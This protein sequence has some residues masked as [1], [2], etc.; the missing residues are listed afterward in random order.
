MVDVKLVEVG[1]DGVGGAIVGGRVV[2][3]ARIAGVGNVGGV[4]V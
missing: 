2:G 4:G 3:G 1:D